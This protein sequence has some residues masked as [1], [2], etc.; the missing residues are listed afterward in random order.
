M[1]R[2]WR[3]EYNQALYHVMSRGN[4]QRDIVRD[5]EDRERFLETLGHMSR[6]QGVEVHAYV[7]MNN[8]YHLLLRT[9][10][11]N[12]SRCMQWLAVTYTRYFNLRHR[13]SGHLFQGRFKSFLVENDEYLM[14]LSCYIHRNPVRAHA[15]ERLADYRWSS[16]QAYAYGRNRAA[17]L[18]P[19]LILSL[20]DEKDKHGA[21][22]RQVQQ[23]AEEA[24]NIWE[25]VKHGLFLGGEEF[26]DTI[27]QK[28]LPDRQ[29]NSEVPQKKKTAKLP[30]IEIQ[31][32]KAARA[33]GLDMEKTAA[34]WRVRPD[35]QEI[36][37]LLL[38]TLWESGQYKNY[39]T[40]KFFGLSYSAVSKR[41][42]YIRRHIEVEP[43]LRKT[44][45][46]IKS[47]IKI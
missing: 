28:L 8:H 46:K 29:G 7:L 41:A 19:S 36:R 31:L 34:R 5:D 43:A 32:Q 3:I 38:Y 11:G 21:Y 18:T 30:D 27:R 45:E 12:L 47:L 1:T 23:Y 2:Q 4:E 33:L 17:W 14:Q 16:Y 22:R 6:R 44:I 35:E 26:A 40:G 9:P 24:R 39:E 10:R 13:R 42:H 20:F 37:D 25:E 15:V